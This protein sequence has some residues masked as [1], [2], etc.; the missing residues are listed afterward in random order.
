MDRLALEVY[1]YVRTTTD[2]PATVRT[3]RNFLLSKRGGQVAHLSPRDLTIRLSRI[4]YEGVRDGYL[5]KGISDGE[6]QLYTGRAPVVYLPRYSP[7]PIS[8]LT[9]KPI[10]VHA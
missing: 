7:S 9:N 6:E 3:I 10:E 1:Q 5:L 8:S 4:L 2:E